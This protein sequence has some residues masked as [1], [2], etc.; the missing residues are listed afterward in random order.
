MKKIIALSFILGSFLFALPAKAASEVVLS[1]TSDKTSY[2]V[3]ED[4]KVTL[5]VNAG[6]Y[7]STLN[8]IDFKLKI[9]DTSVAQPVGSSPLTLGSIYTNTATQSYANGIISA[10]VF[11]D[12]NNK[13]ANRSGVIGTITLKAQKAGQSILSYDSIQAAEEKQEL[14]YVNAT[15]SSLTITVGGGVTAQTTQTTAS[16]SSSSSG[17]T[18]SS[19]R[20]ATAR[21]S[22]AT[23]GPRETLIFSLIAGTLLLVTWKF[24]KKTKFSRKI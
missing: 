4:I 8:V 12:P 3:G 6:P 14:D 16:S 24:T 15:A 17:T 10:V 5:N 13:P 19:V 21:P 20:T 1:A 7:A 23:T 2:N 18:A 11:V 9:S 22:S